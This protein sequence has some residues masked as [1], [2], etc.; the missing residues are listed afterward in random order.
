MKDLGP[1]LLQMASE[2]VREAA[3]SG[4]KARFD[5]DRVSVQ[6]IPPGKEDSEGCPYC[7][8]AKLLAGAYLYIQR[9]KPG[10]QFGT[11]YLS[12]ARAQVLDCMWTLDRL[13]PQETHT[14]MLNRLA[15]IKAHLSKPLSGTAL[16][17]TG[18]DIWN[19]ANIA[20]DLAEV[21]NK[22]RLATAPPVVTI[23]DGESHPI[24]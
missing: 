16:D 15:D 9:A 23:I 8:M 13:P 6:F 24:P 11:L 20:C 1:M 5:R 17:E 3:K 14:R 4:I 18:K 10:T 19:A 2:V 12:L 22:D 21:V 7:Q